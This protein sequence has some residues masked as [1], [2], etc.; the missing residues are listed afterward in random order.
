[1]S[2]FVA[3]LGWRHLDLGSGHSVSGTSKY[4]YAPVHQGILVGRQTGNDGNGP[5]R[6]G[7]CAVKVACTVPTGGMGKHSSAVRQVPTH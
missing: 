5:G 3:E 7:P 1:M 4:Y 6:R 2:G